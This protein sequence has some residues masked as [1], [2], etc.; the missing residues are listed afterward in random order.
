MTTTTVVQSPLGFMDNLG[1]SV[2]YFSPSSTQPDPGHP[3]IIIL[4]S[5]MDA[6][7]VHISKY[8]SQHRL[9]FPTSPILLVKAT[10]AQWL[11]PGLRRDIFAPAMAV[12][13]GV[14]SDFLLHTFSNGG[15][16]S[17]STLWELWTEMVGDEASIP[18]HAVI[19][20]SCPGYFSWTR[21]HHVLSRPL[22]FWASPLVWVFI[23]TVW[24]M[25]IPLGREPPHGL[26][27]A[28]LN[29]KG[30]IAQESK[31]AY[32]YGTQDQSVGWED[33]ERHAQEA[34]QSGSKVRMERFEGSGHVSHMRVD[35]E[36]YWR[37]V[38]ETW[39]GK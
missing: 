28:A 23:A 25:N 18:R 24:A 31:R 19:M 20:D 6:Q 11:R 12:L 14:K 17:A 36:R 9:L 16:S 33:V 22:P 3:S 13:E 26:Y 7:D 30:K 8:I 29:T 37:V 34:K 4:L 10:L 1:P 15:V 27:A 39:E 5:W 32:I 38:K 21:D 2:S 35:G